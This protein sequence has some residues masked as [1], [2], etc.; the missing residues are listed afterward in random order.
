MSTGNII[1]SAF[2]TELGQ[3]EIRGIKLRLSHLDL[4]IIANNSVV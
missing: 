3:S 1:S 2:F 4:A